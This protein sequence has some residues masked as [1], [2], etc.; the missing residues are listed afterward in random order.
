ML[1]EKRGE[2]IGDAA[3]LT[4]VDPVHSD[5]D[6]RG[7]PQDFAHQ[8]Q[9]DARLRQLLVSVDLLGGHRLQVIDYCIIPCTVMSHVKPLGI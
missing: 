2:S 8:H 4:S 7:F 3:A 9:G 1:R 5:A 6:P